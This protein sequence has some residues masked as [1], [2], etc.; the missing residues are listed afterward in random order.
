MLF[1]NK[2]EK[3]VPSETFGKTAIVLHGNK[4]DERIHEDKSSKYA[5]KGNLT[6]TILG[7]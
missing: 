4:L 2:I 3:T 1:F 7:S 5:M 6:T